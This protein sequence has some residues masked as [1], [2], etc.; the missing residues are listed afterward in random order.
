MRTDTKS[1]RANVLK[2][3]RALGINSVRSKIVAN[4]IASGIAHG[5]YNPYSARG[6]YDARGEIGTLVLRLNFAFSGGQYVEAWV[7]GDLA[8]TA[9]T[10]QHL[11]VNVEPT[12]E[13]VALRPQLIAAL[14]AVRSAKNDACRAWDAEN[15][16][17]ANI[18]IAEIR[19]QAVGADADVVAAVA[20]YEALR[21]R[22]LA[23]NRF[24]PLACVD[25]MLQ[26]EYS[27]DFKEEHGSRPGGYIRYDEAVAYFARERR[28]YGVND[29]LDLE[30]AA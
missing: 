14:E 18:G 21:D 10:D 4:R 6:G 28:S 24:A 13:Q 29:D 8:F 3:V 27:D 5:S 1:F 19:H 12:A 23:S 7:D 15:G 2:Q 22:S 25:P 11:L 17:P 26:G 30:D 9:T 20:A 16:H